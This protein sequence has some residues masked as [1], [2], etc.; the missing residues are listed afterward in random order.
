MPSLSL[1]SCIVPVK[2]LTMKIDED[3]LF[4]YLGLWIEWSKKK[5]KKKKKKKNKEERN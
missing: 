3:E 4:A 1:Q 5:K 2:S